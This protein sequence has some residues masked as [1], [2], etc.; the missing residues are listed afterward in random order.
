MLAVNKK[1]LIF[2]SAIIIIFILSSDNLCILKKVTGIPC[3]GCG[4]TRAY[5]SLL[6][7]NIRDAF[8]YNPIF[9]TLPVIIILMI[10]KPTKFINIIKYFILGLIIL[11][12]V[13]RMI[14]FFPEIAPM[15]Y[16]DKSIVNIVRNYIVNFIS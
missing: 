7:L 6:K 2:Y 13:I 16:Y 12:Y 9:W 4:M 11:T 5:L 15:D 8:F 1:Q 14:L 10:K 3:P